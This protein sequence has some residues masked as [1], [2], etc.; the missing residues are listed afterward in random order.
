MD[1]E[2][3]RQTAEA[4]QVFYQKSQESNV[5]EQPTFTA[6]FRNNLW[7]AQNGVC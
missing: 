3:D 2:K 7:V 1:D 4:H 6:L 5:Q